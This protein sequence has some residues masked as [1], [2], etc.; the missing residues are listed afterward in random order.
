M[1]PLLLMAFAGPPLQAPWSCGDSFLVSQGMRL[2]NLDW[3]D[4]RR[5]VNRKA[6]LPSMYLKA[7]SRP[8]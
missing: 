4:P 1:L 7:S 3:D 8:S 5:M 6:A 2:P